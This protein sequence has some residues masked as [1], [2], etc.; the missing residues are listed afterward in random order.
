[1]PYIQRRIYNYLY[2]GW[3]RIVKK[4]FKST[5]LTCQ[6]FQEHFI[7]KTLI[8]SFEKFKKKVKNAVFGS[9]WEILTI[10]KTRLFGAQFASKLV[11]VSF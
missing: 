6:V 9:F 8:W 5:K 11:Y 2:R 7:L 4:N 1:M 10:K 3:G